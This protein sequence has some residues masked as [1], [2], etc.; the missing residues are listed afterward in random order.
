MTEDADAA[1]QRAWV[2]RY[3]PTWDVYTA[4][5]S[6]KERGAVVMLMTH[7]HAHGESPGDEQALASTVGIG[8]DE[9]RP[10]AAEVVKTFRRMLPIM[11][12]QRGKRTGRRT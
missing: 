12:R 9:W 1:F 10:M 3:P 4:H 6:L 11:F 7:Y 2:K 8:L 5:M